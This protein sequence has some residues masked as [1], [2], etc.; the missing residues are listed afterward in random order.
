MTEILQKAAK[1]LISNDGVKVVIGYARDSEG[2][3]KAH[4]AMNPES[5]TDFIFD[6]ECIQN[7]AVYVVKE[8]VK[9][10]GKAGVFAT[11]PTVRSILQV[12]SENQLTEDNLVVMALTG[13]GELHECR[14]FKEME[15]FVASQETEISAEDMQQIRELEEMTAEERWQFWQ[16]QFTK[17][18]KCY[19][20][21]ATCPMC[22][23]GR[24][25]ADFNQPQLIT[26]EATPLGNLEWHTL[27][28]MH[29]AGRCV[30]CGDCGRAC[31]EGIP[32]H[33]LT[34]RATM[35]VAESFNVEVGKDSQMV[36][37]LS[38]FDKED[39]EDFIEHE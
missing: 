20:C 37:A 1:D 33:L 9:K 30:A 39:K 19:A 3:V 34:I 28:A 13:S 26:I 18:I 22:Y 17:C 31:P 10:L 27:R 29:L 8:E 6:E 15:A 16:K 5:T 23:C 7:L 11:L 21:R 35:T 32:I 24:C 14:T 25:Q 4:F 12:A 38:T 2:E 36:S